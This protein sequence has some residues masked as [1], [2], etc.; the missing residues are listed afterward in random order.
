MKII[1]TIRSKE[2]IDVMA[3]LESTK[4]EMFTVILLI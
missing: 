2:L 3:M 1:Y 4:K